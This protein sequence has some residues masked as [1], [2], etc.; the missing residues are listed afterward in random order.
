MNLKISELAELSGV[1][2]RTLQYYDKIG[3][4]KPQ[5]DPENGYRRY[6]ESDIDRLQEVLLFR[7]LNIPL[8]DI[9]DMLEATDYDRLEALKMHRSFIFKRLEG[10]N[11]L[12]QNISRSIDEMEEGIKMATDEKFKGMDFKNN[13]YEDEA[14]QKWGNEKVDKSQAKIN[15]KSEPELT[16]LEN[17]MNEIFKSFSQ[18]RQSDPTAPE[19]VE[20]SERFY[21]FLNGEIGN[22]YNK[23]VF[24]GLGQMYIEDERFTQNLDKWGVGTAQFM[25]D[26]MAYYSDNYL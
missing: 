24:K 26:A 4:L 17:D 25:S 19:A 6:T 8:K 14:R 7:E 21:R 23:E 16:K 13:P 11:L 10:M 18:I 20:V 5:K 12:V 2:V 15:E 22:F 3:L 9:Q 1:T